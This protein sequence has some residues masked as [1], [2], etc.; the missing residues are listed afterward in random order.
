MYYSENL[1]QSIY[2]PDVIESPVNQN[3]FYS[4]ST[5]N[6]L[7][8]LEIKYDLLINKLAIRHQN[9]TDSVLNIDTN[10]KNIVGELSQQKKAQEMLKKR[11]LN[12]Q[13]RI[14][15]VRMQELQ[16]IINSQDD[17]KKSVFEEL[18]LQEKLFDEK[19]QPVLKQQTSMKRK[20]QNNINQQENANNQVVKRLDV[21]ELIN[22]QVEKELNEQ[23]SVNRK[24]IRELDEHEAI[25]LQELQPFISTIQENLANPIA[26]LVKKLS[27][28][29]LVGKIT[30]QGAEIMAKSF[31]DYNYLTNTSTFLLEDNKILLINTNRIDSLTFG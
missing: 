1:K 22:R 26:N 8:E 3:T 20:M 10:Y 31:L 16:S 6:R 17:M 23:E 19:L 29:T 4:N 25:I 7:T 13:R 24:V 27:P 9:L 2:C 28:G 14:E 18:D 12:R 21:Q 11:L 15:K 5:Q 30:V